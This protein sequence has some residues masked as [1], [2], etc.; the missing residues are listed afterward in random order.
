MQTGENIE[1]DLRQ[2]C[3]LVGGERRAEGG[4]M[5]QVADGSYVSAGGWHVL[6]FSFLIYLKGHVCKRL[7]GISQ[8][9]NAQLNVTSRI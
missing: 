7:C 9:L 3:Q 1:C 8:L 2:Y 5:R 6:N 4:G